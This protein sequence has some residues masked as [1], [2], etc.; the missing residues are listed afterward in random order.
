MHQKD[1]PETIDFLLAQV[2][3]L[4]HARAQQLFE[5]LGLYRGQPP[6]L[7]QLWEQEGLSQNELAERMRNTPATVTRMLQ[8][9]EKAGFILRRT[10]EA[11]QRVMRVYL[12]EA[13]RAV[14]AQVERQLAIIEAETFAGFSEE[15]RALLRRCLLQIRGNLRRASGGSS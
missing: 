11:D 14:Q 5:G 7:R 3:H 9:M 12:T 13:G 8:R 4:H 10:D 2:C 1:Q 6:L 15:E